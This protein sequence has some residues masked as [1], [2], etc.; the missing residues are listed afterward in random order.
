[1]LNREHRFHGLGS[2]NFAYRQGQTVRGP[3]L[4]LK[5]APNPR[6]KTYRVAVVVSR[7]VDKSAVARNRMRRRVYEAFQASGSGVTTPHDLI[8]TVFSD[9]AARLEFGEL[10]RQ[11]A[12]LLKKAGITGNGKAGHAIVST[13]GKQT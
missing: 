9:G 8:F 5:Y 11:V 1:M 4:G 12:D 13:E 7:K 3:L 2:L 6:R 10:E